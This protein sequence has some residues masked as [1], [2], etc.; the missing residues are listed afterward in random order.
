MWG[1]WWNSKKNIIIVENEFQ[2]SL[3]EYPIQ[4]AYDI[5]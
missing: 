5:N 1:I 2:K 3:E 4:S